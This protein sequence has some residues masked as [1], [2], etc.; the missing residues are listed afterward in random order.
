MTAPWLGHENLCSIQWSPICNC[1][2]EPVELSETPP[3]EERTA[4]DPWIPT[5][6]GRNCGGQPHE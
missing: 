5:C 2:D 3:V 4:D 1:G 6:D